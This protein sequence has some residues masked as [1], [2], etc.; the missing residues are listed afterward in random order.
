MPRRT[1]SGRTSGEY[2]FFPHRLGIKCDPNGTSSWCLK[3]GERRSRRTHFRR[4][5][6][7]LVIRASLGHTID[8]SAH[9]RSCPFTNIAPVTQN[10]VL[11]GKRVETCC[12]QFDSSLSSFVFTTRA[13]FEDFIKNSVWVAK[14][15]NSNCSRLLLSTFPVHRKHADNSKHN[16]KWKNSMETRRERN[17][18]KRLNSRCV[19]AIAF[20]VQGEKSSR[21]RQTAVGWVI[22][23]NLKSPRAGKLVSRLFGCFAVASPSK[24]FQHLKCNWNRETLAAREFV[25]CVGSPR[26]LFRSPAAAINNETSFSYVTI[27]VVSMRLCDAF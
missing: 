14:R 16:W 9:C 12:N 15:R 21:K 27:I 20:I 1:F 3:N 22:D 5:A 19:G 26:D 13:M 23:C 4:C 10:F 18:K 25:E 6:S 24:F 11:L 17:T 2:E 8:L 7:W